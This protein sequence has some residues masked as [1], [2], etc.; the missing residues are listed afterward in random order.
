M[1]RIVVIYTLL[2]PYIV[3]QP[4]SALEIQGKCRT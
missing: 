1:L 2:G 4:K 3:E